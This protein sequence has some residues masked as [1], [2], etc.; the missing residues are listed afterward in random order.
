MF[1]RYY[2]LNSHLSSKQTMIAHAH[3]LCVTADPQHNTKDEKRNLWRL[4][5]FVLLFSNTANTSHLPPHQLARGLFNYKIVIMLFSRSLLFQLIYKCTQARVWSSR[6][7]CLSL[8]PELK[9]Q[10]D[11]TTQMY[12]LSLSSIELALVLIFL[13]LMKNRRDHM[14]MMRFSLTDFCCCYICSGK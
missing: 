10:S 13:G 4:S 2:T 3:F 1:Q 14:I 12:R 5:I 11:V 7:K 8:L 9:Y 6:L